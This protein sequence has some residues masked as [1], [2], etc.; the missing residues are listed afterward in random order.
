MARLWKYLFAAHASLTTKMMRAWAAKHYVNL[1]LN[2]VAALFLVLH[3]RGGHHANRRR[4]RALQPRV[5]VQQ[6]HRV[7]GCSTSQH[8]SGREAKVVREGPVPVLQPRH[9]GPRNGTNDPD[10]LWVGGMST[11]LVCCP[12]LSSFC[13]HCHA[14][15]HPAR[16]RR[17]PHQ[18]HGSEEETRI[19][20]S[21]TA[22]L[23][24]IDGNGWFRQFSEILLTI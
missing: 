15:L 14:H 1:M 19:G 4:R 24:E 20:N 2:F 22:T 10:L 7:V 8:E 11:Q 13:C 18:G 5:A 23:H 12:G 9:L 3:V 6:E 17:S 16:Q 21:A